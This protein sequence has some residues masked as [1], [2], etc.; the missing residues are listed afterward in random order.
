MFTCRIPFVW[1]YESNGTTF[2][3][4]ACIQAIALDNT[5]VKESNGANAAG[6]RPGQ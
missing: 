5:V 4:F 3:V 2:I 1:L 6:V